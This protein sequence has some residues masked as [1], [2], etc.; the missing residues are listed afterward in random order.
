M[1]TSSAAMMR[2][3]S[4]CSSVVAAAEQD[5]ELV[6]A[7]ARDAVGVGHGATQPRAHLAQ[8]VVADAVAQRV[9][10]VLEAVQVHHEDAELVAPS[11][12]SPMAR[13][14]SL[15]KRE[16]LARSVEGSS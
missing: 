12:A 1:G 8:H 14:S 7:E 4:R 3:P 13:A 10:D 11:M 15:E 6:A 16:R 9:V 2:W 5:G